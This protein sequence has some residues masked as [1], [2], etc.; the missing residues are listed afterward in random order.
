MAYNCSKIQRPFL[1][2][3]FMT[4]A[5][6][7]GIQKI[8]CRSQLSVKFSGYFSRQQIDQVL[9]ILITGKWIN[10]NIPN[11]SDTLFSSFTPNAKNKRS[12]HFKGPPGFFFSVVLEFCLA[13]ADGT[14]CAKQ[15][16]E[17]ESTLAFLPISFV[18]SLYS[19]FL[20]GCGTF[21]EIWKNEHI[22]NDNLALVHWSVFFEDWIFLRKMSLTEMSA[23]SYTTVWV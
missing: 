18:I 8:S 5:W 19:V 15:V 22:L 13:F 11:F 9:Y 2:Y 7:G 3:C 16:E 17:L 21:G 12:S 10:P 20:G 14:L 4:A 23:K 6:S 1:R